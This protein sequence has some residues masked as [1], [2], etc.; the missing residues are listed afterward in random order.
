M[1]QDRIERSVEIDA[2]KERVWEIITKPEHVGRWFGQGTP[3][4]VDLRVGGVMEIEP[5]KGERCLT[6][7]V[8]VTPP[9]Y[10]AY[11]W[12]AAYPGVLADETNS[13][14]VEFRLTEEAGKTR[15]TLCE[16]GFAALAIP[17]GREV[18]ASYDSHNQGW[19]EVLVNLARYAEEQFPS[20]EHAHA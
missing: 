7:I 13:T 3:A 18:F 12:A 16:S 4:V 6:Q 19:G 15:L 5:A 11:R 10:F 9:D 1:D 2:S 20:Q 8:A 14:L 17:T